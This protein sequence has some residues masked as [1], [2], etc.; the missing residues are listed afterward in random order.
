MDKNRIPLRL[1]IGLALALVLAIAITFGV[2]SQRA[3]PGAQT[4]AFNLG[5]V[6]LPV[7]D[8]VA[9]Y[10]GLGVDCGA[11]VTD[12]SPGSRAEQAGIRT[13]DVITRFNGAAITQETPL[14]GMMRE[15]SPEG[16]I[17]ME[18]QNNNTTREVTILQ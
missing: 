16:C 11:L 4:G 2:Q 1:A 8:S 9:G 3:G 6:Y 7:N 13:G 18:V 12:V 15:C 10:Y 5:F 14:L 17:T